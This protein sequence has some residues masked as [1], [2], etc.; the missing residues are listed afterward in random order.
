MVPTLDSGS[1][2][3]GVEVVGGSDDA[4]Y[5]TSG[6]SPTLHLRLAWKR[7]KWPPIA[8]ALGA[9]FA[10][11]PLVLL[12]ASGEARVV[13]L[14]L[15]L[16]LS[17]LVALFSYDALGRWINRTDIVAGERFVTVRHKPLPW[18]GGERVA[19]VKVRSLRVV[20]TGQGARA[21]RHVL[22]VLDDGG[23][24]QLLRS[25]TSIGM[26]REQAEFIVQRLR[27]HLRLREIH[28]TIR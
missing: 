14:G 18:M 13:G 9:G 24:V 27:E 15:W 22:A 12:S 26:T 21:G 6:K 19:T 10:L 7:G 3:Q 2:P 16:A 23:G 5:R 20:E 8:M 17:P 4:G 25:N 1:A 28:G 11:I